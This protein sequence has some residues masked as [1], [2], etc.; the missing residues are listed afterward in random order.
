[1]PDFTVALVEDAIAVGGSIAV[2]YAL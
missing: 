1:M 2:V